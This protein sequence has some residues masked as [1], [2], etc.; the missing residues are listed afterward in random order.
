M[1]DVFELDRIYQRPFL[2]WLGGKGDSLDYIF[3]E[4]PANAKRFIE[5]FMGSGIVGLNAEPKIKIMS[6][7]NRDLVELY[8][9]V[10][11]TPG[12][13]VE[14][15]KT[16]FLNGNNQDTYYKMR[17]EFNKTPIGSI[18]RAAMFVYLNRHCFNGVCRYNSSGEFNVPF[19]KYTSIG[20]PQ[21]EIMSFSVAM[22]NT[23]FVCADFRTVFDVALPG[24]VFYCDPPYVP[25]VESGFVNYSGEGFSPKDQ[26]DLAD[27]ARKA[28]KNGATVL[29]SNHW[30]D[31]IEELYAGATLRQVYVRRSVASKGTG[32][33][34]TAEVLAIFRP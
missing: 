13:F 33:A 32:R 19:G 21:K 30:V 1:T 7:M 9:H 24:D 25:V 12:Q 11:R 16:Y 6:D 26:Q 29:I 2:K 31:G 4:V 14:L 8:Q 18:E 15:A 28:C 20:L 17:D 5:P 3:N 34:R 10:V 22:Q 27:C 23:S